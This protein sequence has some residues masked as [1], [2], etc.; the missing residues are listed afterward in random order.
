M[1]QGGVYDTLK[2]F[3]LHL[4]N[5]TFICIRWHDIL[6]AQ[7]DMDTLNDLVHRLNQFL[8]T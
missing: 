4:T 8:H 3:K 2:T 1:L 6:S 7:F 5:F